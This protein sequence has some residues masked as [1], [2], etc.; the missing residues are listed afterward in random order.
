MWLSC[1]KWPAM[2]PASPICERGMWAQ[3]EFEAEMTRMGRGTLL[4]GPRSTSSSQPWISCSLSLQSPLIPQDRPSPG[5][6]PPSQ[7]VSPA[8][9]HQVVVAPQATLEREAP[10]IQGEVVAIPAH[11]T[12][13]R[14]PSLGTVPEAILAHTVGTQSGTVLCDIS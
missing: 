14:A 3:F 7:T 1:L 8:H 9:V 6:M 13:S 2:S 10:P 4:G 11:C 5:K 12:L